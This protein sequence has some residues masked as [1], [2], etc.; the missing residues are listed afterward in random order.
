MLASA[1]R[2]KYVM[3][4]GP[5]FAELIESAADAAV[6]ANPQASKEAANRAASGRLFRLI[7]RF[8]RDQLRTALP[9]TVDSSFHDGACRAI[10]AVR[11]AERLLDAQVN[12]AFVGEWLSAELVAAAEP[13]NA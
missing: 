6:K 10:D 9:R 4:L 11:G 5:K 13:Q 12:L 1:S 3:G 8:Y 2:G 7:S